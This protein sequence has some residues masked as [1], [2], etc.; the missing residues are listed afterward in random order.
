MRNNTG[1]DEPLPGGDTLRFLPRWFVI[2]MRNNRDLMS[3]C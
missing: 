3:L 2:G 1:L